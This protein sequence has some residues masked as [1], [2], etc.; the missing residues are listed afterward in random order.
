M[1]SV[2]I[3]PN[4]RGMDQVDESWV[5]QEIH[6]YRR[7]GE[8]VCVRVRIDTQSMSISLVTP[9]CGGGGG[10]GA[11]NPAERHAVDLWRKHRLGTMEFTG[12][13]L[14]AF[15]HELRRML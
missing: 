10:G 14:V 12:G 11:L 7:R 5:N 15:L 2:K 4:E 8:S 13:N 9:G 1:I 3:G 6:R